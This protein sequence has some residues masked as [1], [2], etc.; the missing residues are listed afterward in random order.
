MPF[1]GK[2]EMPCALAV[3]EAHVLLSRSFALLGSTSGHDFESEDIH[4][5]AI[6]IDTQIEML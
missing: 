1:A 4:Y 6:K 5:Y 2:D 3:V